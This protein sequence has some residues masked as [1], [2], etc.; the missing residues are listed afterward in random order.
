MNAL[1]RS[2]H[3]ICAAAGVEFGVSP[4]GNLANNTDLQYRNLPRWMA[5]GWVD[6]V[7]P[8]IY[9][10]FDWRSAE[11]SDSCAFDV[12]LQSWLD[13]PRAENVRL[14][15]GLGACRI[16]GQDGSAAESGEWQSGGQLAKM[17][18]HLR[19]ARAQGYA[20]YRY[21]SLWNADPLCG[22]ELEA[23]RKENTP[24]APGP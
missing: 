11:G 1:I 14:Y 24:L 13:L 12:C 21:G 7:C 19:G 18:S 6:Y 17:V 22:Q 16:G 23:L 15:A 9:W 8:Q 5:E 3:E 2:V 20:V 10:G 4:Q